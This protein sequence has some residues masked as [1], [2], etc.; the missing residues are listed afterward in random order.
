MNVLKVKEPVT[1]AAVIEAVQAGDV[2]IDDLCVYVEDDAGTITP[3]LVC[4]LDAYPEIAG[5]VEV[6][7]DFV[8]SNELELIY[9]GQQFNDVLR[10][11][12]EQEASANIVKVV[13]ALNYYLENDDFMEVN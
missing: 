5:D 2:I 11:V 3:E 13:S 1:V 4:Y 9:Y 12:F 10:S 6:Y 8:T 7:S